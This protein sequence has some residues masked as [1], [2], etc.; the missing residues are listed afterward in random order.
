MNIS[1]PLTNLEPDRQGTEAGTQN[2]LTSQ[3]V[4]NR[5]SDLFIEAKWGPPIWK[6]EALVNKEPMSGQGGGQA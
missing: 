3:P 6:G 1:G 5:T 4:V 2:R